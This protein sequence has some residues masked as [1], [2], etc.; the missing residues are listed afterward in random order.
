MLWCE[1]EPL[2]WRE[3]RAIATAISGPEGNEEEVNTYMAVNPKPVLLGTS[4]LEI[5]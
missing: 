1:R 5:G 3:R 2:E 4:H